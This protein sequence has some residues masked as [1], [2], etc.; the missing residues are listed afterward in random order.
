MIAQGTAKMSGI[1]SETPRSIY[2]SFS[3]VQEVKG[4]DGQ[5]LY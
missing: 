1:V 2:A 3:F 4:F 5:G